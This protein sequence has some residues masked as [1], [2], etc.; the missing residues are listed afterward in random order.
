M[1]GLLFFIPIQTVSDTW[2]EAFSI[3]SRFLK[4]LGVF[5]TLWHASDISLHLAFVE[6]KWNEISTD[7]EKDGDS[8]ESLDC[9]AYKINQT[10][11]RQFGVDVLLDMLTYL[12]ET[13]FCL[14]K[15]IHVIYTCR[16]NRWKK[17]RASWTVG[18]KLDLMYKRPYTIM[19]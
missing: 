6:V 2:L 17:T 7:A 19:I 5:S 18:L 14:Q 4:W 13:H 12:F 1:K 10:I 15:V 8:S 16:M 11:Y 3:S 9:S